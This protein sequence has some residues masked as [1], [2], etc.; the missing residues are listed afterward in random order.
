MPQPYRCASSM[1]SSK[2]TLRRG[3]IPVRHVWCSLHDACMTVCLSDCRIT[4]TRKVMMC[5]PAIEFSES[6]DSTSLRGNRADSLA[7]RNRG[8]SRP[9]RSHPGSVLSALSVTE[10]VGTCRHALSSKSVLSSARASWQQGPV[11]SCAI[12]S[13][14]AAR[15]KS[16]FACEHLRQH[17]V[18]VRPG[19]LGRA[20]NL[21]LIAHGCQG[22]RWSHACERAQRQSVS[23]STSSSSPLVDSPGYCSS[24][25]SGPVAA[26][27]QSTGLFSGLTGIISTK[28][29][30]ALQRP[31]L[32]A[33][34]HKK[35][36]TSQIR[37]GSNN[38]M[39]PM[40]ASV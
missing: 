15:D 6:I 35:T 11:S 7:L 19:E 34:R 36:G 28:P 39:Q 12:C 31:T 38:Y 40:K 25:L 21:M 29:C 1:A 5:A 14:T 23:G 22:Y 3:A 16:V 20:C 26:E 32:R 17:S 27:H 13:A 18:T 8:W 33:A 24:R 10:R 2:I 37:T 30:A 4:A 9:P